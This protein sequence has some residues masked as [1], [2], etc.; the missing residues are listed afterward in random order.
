MSS[1]DK[2]IEFW[3][4]VLDCDGLGLLLV[5]VDKE[6]LIEFSF[7]YYTLLIH[8]SVFTLIY[9]VLHISFESFPLT[10]LLAT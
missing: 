8:I 2:E 10:R 9:K 3:Y 1:A 5:Q 7:V 4:K 6:N